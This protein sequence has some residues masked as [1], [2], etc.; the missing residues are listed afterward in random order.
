MQRSWLHWRFVPLAL[1]G[2]SLSLGFCLGREQLALQ[3][4]SPLDW[5]L[6]DWVGTRRDAAS[7]EKV[8]LQL[9]VEPILGGAG[10]IEHLE[11]QH[12]DG[13]YRGFTVLTPSEKAGKWVM[14][15]WNSKRTG[16]AQLNGEVDEARSTW[17]SASPEQPRRSRLVSELVAKNEWRRTMSISEDQGATWRVLW[18]DELRRT[19]QR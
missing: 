1:V 7:D 3:K 17:I 4:P 8:K 16:F 10:E 5:T 19:R 13:L 6:G 9:R 18:I 11:A 15:Y 2:A 12:K 14:L